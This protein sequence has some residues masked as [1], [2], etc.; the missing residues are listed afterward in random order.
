MTNNRENLIKVL[1][2]LRANSKVNRFPILESII[3]FIEN[4]KLNHSVALSEKVAG[5]ITYAKQ[6]DDIFD[7]KHV[8][9]TT[10]PRY[11]RRQMGVDSF[12]LSDALLD[13]INKA[14]IY[15]VSTTSLLSNYI[16]IIKGDDI[17]YY[18]TN[19]ASHSCMTGA[20]SM[21]IDVYAENPDKVSLLTTKDYSRALLWN[22]DDGVVVLDRIY[23]AGSKS[24]D[25]IRKWAM[26]QGH[27]LRVVPDKVVKTFNNVQ[28]SDDKQHFV[29]LKK[30]AYF[31]YTDTFCYGTNVDSSK[32]LL[33]N[34]HENCR[35]VL[36]SPYG[37]YMNICQCDICKSKF[38]ESNL[39]YHNNKQYCEVCFANSFFNCCR[40]SC[41]YNRDDGYL[42]NGSLFCE[43]CYKKYGVMCSHCE[44]MGLNSGRKIKSKKII[45]SS[46]AS[47]YFE[48]CDACG[49]F[50]L[51]T[52]I[53]NCHGFYCKT[54]YDS[55]FAKCSNCETIYKKGYQVMFNDKPY[56]KD[57]SHKIIKC[58]ICNDY[59]FTG[60][61]VFIKDNIK[62][63]VC[64]PC[65]EKADYVN[66]S[67][68]SSLLLQ[69]ITNNVC[70]NCLALNKAPIIPID[71]QGYKFRYQLSSNNCYIIS[72]RGL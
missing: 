9:R 28:L 15:E 58:F 20:K 55:T 64:S 27:V 18:Y 24:V 61:T 66:C 6:P 48:C 67:Q 7:P 70:Y 45:C 10:L 69:P 38:I 3:S 13:Q 33:T 16:Q 63:N 12:T 54:C 26:E 44:K 40:C 65:K 11:I 51:K 30:T 19:I 8:I 22:C 56:C 34:Y 1:H 53:I 41:I 4:D 71:K 60:N 72:D 36:H 21:Y 49:L 68:C 42:L 35:F 2:A 31:P 57:C 29:M 62:V 43:K 52:D 39:N 59:Y 32:M 23:P 14:F 37:V 5:A 46:C 25:M 50:E 47:N 17:K